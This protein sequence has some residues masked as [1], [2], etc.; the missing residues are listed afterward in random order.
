MEARVHLTTQET[1]L[2]Q[3]SQKNCKVIITAAPTLKKV[4]KI[5]S[6]NIFRLSLYC[7]QKSTTGK[8]F[9]TIKIDINTTCN[10]KR[11]EMLSQHFFIPCYKRRNG[12]ISVLVYR[13]Q[14]HFDQFIY[15]IYHHQTSSKKSAVFFLFSEED[16]TLFRMGWGWGGEAVAKSPPPPPN[17]FFLCKFH[18]RRIWPPKFSDFQF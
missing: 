15:Y 3:K 14:N 8:S 1:F 4:L 13:K 10:M 2:K 16:L 5:L 18:K 6:Y 11:K 7:N 9:L 17:Q 12:S